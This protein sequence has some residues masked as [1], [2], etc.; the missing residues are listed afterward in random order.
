MADSIHFQ[1]GFNIPVRLTLRLSLTAFNLAGPAREPVVR[2]PCGNQLDVDVLIMRFP[3]S[4]SLS[5]A[6]YKG[7]Q[8]AH[9]L[10][11]VG[12]V[13]PRGGRWGQKGVGGGGH[14]KVNSGQQGQSGRGPDHSI[15]V[16]R[17]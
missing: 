11:C 8:D 9:Q 14:V 2:L 6:G 16:W 12:C 4:L 1:C 17:K 15:Y 7:V 5:L 10:V 3:V 13:T